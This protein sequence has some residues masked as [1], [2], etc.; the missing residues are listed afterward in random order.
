[1]LR[2]PKL[3]PLGEDG[4]RELAERI[5]DPNYR[6]FAE[7]GEIHIINGQMYLRGTDPFQLFD[8]LLTRDP[9][10]D[11]SHAFYLGYELAKAVMALTLGK[12]YCQDQTLRWGF[13]TVPEVSHRG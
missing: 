2:D 10:I 11:P 4:L 13:L 7:R 1:M 5:T 8:E 6:V 9:R 3:L 12:N